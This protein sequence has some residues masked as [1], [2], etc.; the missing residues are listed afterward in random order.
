L[1][2]CENTESDNEINIIAIMY[3][4]PFI[5][6]LIQL[7][8]NLLILPIVMKKWLYILFISSLSLA[9]SKDKNSNIPLVNVDITIYTSN[10]S[11]NVISVPGGWTYINGGS[12]GI[13]V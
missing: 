9:C 6:V 1:V 10:P 8:S 2:S 3:L 13:I 4:N 7:K 11:Y 12:R 5:F